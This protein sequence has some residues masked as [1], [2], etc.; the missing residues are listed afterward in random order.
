ML[1]GRLPAPHEPHFGDALWLS[2][3][4]LVAAAGS[5]E[6][7]W[8]L[9]F[10]LSA[11]IAASGFGAAWLLA[12]GAPWQRGCAA[13]GAGLFLAWDPGHIDSAISGARGY[14]APELVA[15]GLLG[16]AAGARGRPWGAALAVG[17]FFAA[18]HHHP[19]SAGLLL[20]AALLAA[21]A[22][23]ASAGRWRWLAVVVGLLLLASGVGR[24][25]AG[26]E[27]RH[28]GLA[29]L[30]GVAMD[31]ASASPLAHLELLWLALEDFFMAEQAWGWWLLP[32]GLLLALPWRAA[33]LAL[34]A[35]LGV[36]LLGLAVHHLD[37]HHLRLA[38]APLAVA[39][40]LGWSRLARLCRWLPALR[41]LGALPLLAALLALLSWRLPPYLDLPYRAL[42]D[43][44][45]LAR[46]VAAQ[47]GPVWLDRAGLDR[48]PCTELSGV[49]LSMVLQDLPSDHLGV[50]QAATMLLASCGEIPG[51]L[52]L[53]W[54][55][56]EQALL[57]FESV[58]AA[59]TW[60]EGFGVSRA[61]VGD[62]AD[63]LGVLGRRPE[64]VDDS[65]WWEL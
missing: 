59:R 58:Q 4:P 13:L 1:D 28:E 61:P 41:A 32:L 16:L 10:L 45:G 27:L 8:V 25:L 30:L 20:G 64:G 48:G 47:P 3:L 54:L 23:R 37:A 14:W 56:H 11:S 17:G 31:S 52:D 44:D 55:G 63:A 40:S 12:R 60:R 7:L 38:I 35:L 46:Q 53:V 9:R 42:E 6:Q 18:M 2:C 5:L 34:A 50:D 29:G 65:R 33:W 21:P 15:L 19:M 26:R 49:T 43:L 62:A 22:W 51:G 24:L 36:A 39:A 57:R